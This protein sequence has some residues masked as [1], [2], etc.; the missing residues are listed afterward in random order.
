MARSA[1]S[2]AL[3]AALGL[4]LAG[5]AAG[6][7][8]KKP[9]PPAVSSYVSPPLTG[10]VGTPGVTGG[11]AQTFTSGADIPGDWWTLYHSTTIN[12][13]IDQ[14]LKANADLAAAQAALKQAH[15]TTL[16]QKGAFFPQVSAGYSAQRQLQ[17]GALA[18][19]PI[20]NASQFNLF[21]PQVSVTY[22][23]DAFGLTRRTVEA[24]R[25]QEE[26]ARFQMIAAHLT[27]TSSVVVAAIQDASLAEQVDA[28]RKLID[29]ET[30]SVEILKYQQS[31]GYASGV[32]V[33]AQE[34]Q[35]AQAQASLPP[36]IHQADQQHDALAVLVGQFPSQMAPPKLDLASL[37]LPA[38]LPLS[39]PSK[40]VEQRPDVRQAEANLHAASA[41]IGVAAANR[42]PNIQLTAIAGNT[43]LALSRAFTP[44]TNF[45]SLGADATLPIFTGGTLLHQ[46]RAAKAAYQ[47]AAAQYR[48][49]VLGAFQNVA[50]SLSAIQ[51]DAEGLKAAARAD[52]AA[53]TT[54]DLIQRQLQDG[55]ASPLQLLNAQQ[56][57]QQ[58]RLT[59]VQA[60]AARF[61]D[62][63]ALYQSLG[64][65]WWKRPD[66]AKDANAN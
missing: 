39:L 1:R 65:G 12:A 35:L 9:A 42:L 61:S 52:A 59:L 51:Q 54:L 40:L 8:F 44:G 14:A 26:A 49:T 50:D 32:D 62:T 47:Q 29:I 34:T 43:A 4:A 18:P 48:S 13:L 53:K 21:T 28:T 6:P 24:A 64:G 56:A 55:Y 45:W 27:L 10:A 33:A 30:K 16:A 37:T 57:Y 15:E 5:C 23:L 19:T 25:A 2:A 60:E 3:T 41:Q 17:S 36:L 46:E 58:A 31:K 11:A 22:T 7:D 66:L 63:V 38:D 20:D